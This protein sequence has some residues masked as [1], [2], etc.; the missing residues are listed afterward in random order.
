MCTPY[1]TANESGGFNETKMK[2][3]IYDCED[4][5]LDISKAYRDGKFFWSARCVEKT[6]CTN[7]LAD[8]ANVCLTE[9]ACTNSELGYLGYL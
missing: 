5:Y 6:A 3:G 7:I 2:Q 4:K 8:F 1:I 9:E